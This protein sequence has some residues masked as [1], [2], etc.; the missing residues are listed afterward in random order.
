MNLPVKTSPFC[1]DKLSWSCKNILSKQ[2]L[3]FSSFSHFARA[4]SSRTVSWSWSTR[5]LSNKKKLVFVV[6]KLYTFNQY[7]QYYRCN[8]GSN[9]LGHA[10]EHQLGNKIRLEETKHTDCSMSILIYRFNLDQKN[11]LKIA[12]PK[13]T[14]KAIGDVMALIRTLQRRFQITW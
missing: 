11:L 5:K 13:T 14:I 4:I 7:Y 6:L 8:G 2:C 10:V 1:I 3:L 9:T 12:K